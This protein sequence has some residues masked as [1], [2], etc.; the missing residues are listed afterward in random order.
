MNGHDQD[1]T[2]GIPGAD[3][4]PP[5]PPDGRA[6]AE[7]GRPGRDP[8]VEVHRGGL[9]PAGRADGCRATQL[10]RRAATAVTDLPPVGN[11]VEMTCHRSGTPRPEGAEFAEPAAGPPRRR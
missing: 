3:R 9:V 2:W 11:Q 7:F 10:A 5:P 6:G 8:R 4:D 1:T